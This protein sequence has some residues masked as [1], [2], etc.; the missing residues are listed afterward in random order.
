MEFFGWTRWLR[1]PEYLAHTNDPVSYLPW[2]RRDERQNDL[3]EEDL[4]ID[5]PIEYTKH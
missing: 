5:F 2:T 4:A 3:E 1:I